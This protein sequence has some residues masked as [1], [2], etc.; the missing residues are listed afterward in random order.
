MLKGANQ[1]RQVHRVPCGQKSR[2][3]EHVR[4]ACMANRGLNLRTAPSR[5]PVGPL[6]ASSQGHKASRQTVT[7]STEKCSP[8]RN[9]VVH[10]GQALRRDLAPLP[11]HTPVGEEREVEQVAGGGRVHRG[12]GLQCMDG[13][14]RAA[15]GARGMTPVQRPQLP[16]RWPAPLAEPALFAVCPAAR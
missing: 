6:L 16:G 9:G 14:C 2:S 13:E 11:G 4:H 15:G 7:K 3:C 10:A 8:T 5:T 12:R 1:V